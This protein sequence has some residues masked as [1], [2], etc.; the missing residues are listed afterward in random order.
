MKKLFKVVGIL[1]LFLNPNA[2]SAE[3]TK[4]LL[5][6]GWSFKGFFGKFDRSSLQRGYQVYTEVC[7]ACHSL[8]YLSY[9]N[10][11]EKGGPEFSIEQAK[12]KLDIEKQANEAKLKKDLMMFEFEL[13]MKLEKI[14]ADALKG[15]EKEKEDRKDERTRIQATQQSE[16]IDQRNNDKLPK[17][18]ESTSNDTMGG[19]FGLGGFDPR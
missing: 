14:K 3:Q 1:F 18:F 8:N 19:G 16:L 17:N 13:N 11:S 12:A 15:K 2:F 10:L 5:K 9:R 4:T 7:A 6:P